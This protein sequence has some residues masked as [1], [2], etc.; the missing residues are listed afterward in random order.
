MSQQLNYRLLSVGGG[1][2]Q[3]ALTQERT[4]YIKA[5]SARAGTDARAYVA[6]KVSAMDDN[7]RVYIG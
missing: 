6:A 3:M 2:D 1:S 4:L 5:P 7:Q